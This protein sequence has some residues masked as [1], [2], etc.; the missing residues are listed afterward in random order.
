MLI[1]TPPAVQSTGTVVAAKAGLAVNG[2]IAR[3][4][5]QAAQKRPRTVI[6]FIVEFTILFIVLL[7]FCLR[8]LPWLPHSPGWN[9][10]SDRL[11]V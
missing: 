3:E 4:M 1:E 2:C 9:R 6:R 11:A 8:V 5:M 7:Q 10:S